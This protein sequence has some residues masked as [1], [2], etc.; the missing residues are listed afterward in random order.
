MAVAWLCD[1]DGTIAPADIGASWVRRFG[2]IPEA[3]RERLLARWKR[4]EIGSRELTLAECEGLACGEA[5]ALAFARGFRLDPDFAPFVREARGRGDA[6][7]VVSDGFDF[8]LRDHLERAGLA[9]LPWASNHVRFGEGAVALEF[10]AGDGGCGRCG[11]CKAPFVRRYQALGFHTVLVG[12]GF[13]DRCPAPLADAVLAK[14]GL[15]GWCRER[16]IPA[17][18]FET[19][20]D[21]ADFGRRLASDL[22]TRR[23]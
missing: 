1:F 19:F 15:L 23:V 16:G 5:E 10:A 21:V 12:D 14:G 3:E 17:R 2:A 20:G 6:V 8:Y 18:G 22:T 11:N 7:M 13:S 4:G 9:D